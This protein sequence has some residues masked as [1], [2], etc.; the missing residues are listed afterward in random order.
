MCYMIAISI[1][2][3]VSIFYIQTERYN[4]KEVD[5]PETQ[6]VF[7]YIEDNLTDDEVVCFFKP[8]LLYYY[9]NSNSY[10][11]FNNAG[12]LDEADYYLWTNQCDE[13]EVLPYAE[14]HGTIIFENDWYKLFD[15][16]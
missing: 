11:W 7:A 10:T 5:S 9:T 8:R 2:L 1:A 15:L 6:E 4:L 16:K 13:S 12:H 3:V 14:E